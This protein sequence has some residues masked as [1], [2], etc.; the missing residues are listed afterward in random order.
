VLEGRQRREPRS[1]EPVRRRPNVP[2]TLHA[3]LMARAW[4][5]WARPPGRSRRS[6]A[7]LGREFSYEAAGGR[8]T[9]ERG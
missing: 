8:R 5:G 4:I 7:A 3:S 6:G 1:H 2:A 9:A